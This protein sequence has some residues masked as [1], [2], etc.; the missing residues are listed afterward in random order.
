MSRWVKMGLAA[1]GGL[2]L[3]EAIPIVCYIIATSCFGVF[4]HDGG[5]AM[6]AVFVIGPLLAVVLAILAATVA[7]LWGGKPAGRR[8]GAS[9]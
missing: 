6:G 4:D 7:A 2:V 8:A 9:F 1:L 5:T 3:G